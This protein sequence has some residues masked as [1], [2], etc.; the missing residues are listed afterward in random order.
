M[1]RIRMWRACQMSFSGPVDTDDNAVPAALRA[2]FRNRMLEGTG[3]AV[4][5]VNISLS[6]ALATWSPSDP[7]LTG[8]GGSAALNWFGPWGATLSDALMRLLG[9]GTLG[10]LA[11]PTVWAMEMIAHKL[12]QK[13]LR[14]MLAW[15]IWLLV[16]TGFL[17]LLPQP[18][19]LPFAEGLGG[20]IG[21]FVSAGLLWIL[22]FGLKGT[23]A[24]IVS[25][26]LLGFVSLSAFFWAINHPRINALLLAAIFGERT[27]DVIDASVGALGHFFYSLVSAFGRARHRLK[28][29]AG[30]HQDVISSPGMVRR[31]WAWLF[32]PAAPA[33]EAR[34]EPQLPKPRIAKPGRQKKLATEETGGSE[35][36]ELDEEDDDENI[37]DDAEADGEE[38]EGPRISRSTKQV[39]QS[40]GAGKGGRPIVYENFNMPPLSLLAEPKHFGRSEQESDE[41][42]E[43]NARML[44]SVLDDFGVR[45]E[46]INVRPGPVVTLYELEP[47]PGI[48]SSRVIGLADDIARSM[49]AVACRVAVVSGRNVIGIELPNAKRETVYL[50]E[51]LGSEVFEKT[52]QS[53]CLA[54]GKNIGGEPVFADLSRMPHLL[55]AGTTGSGK[56]VGINTM[57]LSLLYRMP[58]ERCKL[59]MIDPK[60]LELS[61]YEGIPHL[62]APVVTD[63]RK[64]VVALKWAVREMEDRYR[65]MSKL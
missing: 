63:P 51:L 61:V 16:L 59:I 41:L 29:D 12:P 15:T 38:G 62:L 48:K 31:L 35:E 7:G 5:A 43:Q 47:A 9:L 58:Q 50:R 22:S 20:A 23:F 4:L 32:T 25:A 45:G 10:L 53:L 24:A 2:F 44:E 8:S 19:G 64:A 6:L 42:L 33:G 27:H 46:I 40:K 39:K 14:R 17:S 34:H 1:R 30:A 56:S 52:A 13:P 60:M 55:I 28:T 37:E 21:S 3:L 18:A 26:V 54:L 36:D 57:I 11:V 49:S 65:K